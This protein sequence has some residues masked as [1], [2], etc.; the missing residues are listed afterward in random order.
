MMRLLSAQFAQA[1]AS[2]A[3]ALVSAAPAQAAPREPAPTVLVAIDE[4]VALGLP[5][6]PLLLKAREGTAKGVPDAV[7]AAAVRDLAGRMSKVEA[8][9]VGPASP[10][11]RSAVLGA[12]AAALRAG[13]STGSLKRLA[14]LPAD[15][16]A[17]AFQAVGDLVALG[18]PE[19]RSVVL[20][21][22]ASMS[23]EGAATLA[24]LGSTVASMLAQGMTTTLAVEELST[25]SSGLA[26]SPPKAYG[27]GGKK[28]HE[29]KGGGVE[30]AP[31]Q[32]KN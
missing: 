27:A 31:G 2:M 12:G 29:V 19:D 17:P 26:A 25:G 13:V 5:R 10:L 21:E 22:R 4:G 8:A 20:V 23:M 32:G 18:V 24:G 11:D 3:F 1:V 28:G 6:E 7:V 9:L 15:R 16:V 30:N 14:A